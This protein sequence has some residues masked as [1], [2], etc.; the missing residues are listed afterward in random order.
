[1]GFISTILSLSLLKEPRATPPNFS[2]SLSLS[3]ARMDD[4]RRRGR[5]QARPRAAEAAARRSQARAAGAAARRA[6]GA[7][8]RTRPGAACAA[9][10]GRG[11]GG[12]RLGQPEIGDF[13]GEWVSPCSF[14]KFTFGKALD[15]DLLIE[16]KFL[17]FELFM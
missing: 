13:S 1:M 5:S 14:L 3:L 16:W 6:A 11:R 12:G 17:S 4:S 15:L 8:A 2:L 7:A 9:L 10:R